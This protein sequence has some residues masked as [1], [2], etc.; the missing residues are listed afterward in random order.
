[1]NSYSSLAHLAV[2]LHNRPGLRDHDR[3][4]IWAEP[5]LFWSP[6]GLWESEENISFFLC[7]RSLLFWFPPSPLSQ[8]FSA[9]C[10]KQNISIPGYSPCNPPRVTH[11]T[12]KEAPPFFPAK[13]FLRVFKWLSSILLNKFL[14]CEGYYIYIISTNILFYVDEYKSGAFWAKN[15]TIGRSDSWSGR[16]YEHVIMLKNII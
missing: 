5:V 6:I 15:F 1:M 7:R 2:T 14:C 12:L 10:S 16:L 4:R 8:A 13:F 11:L 3:L 9:F